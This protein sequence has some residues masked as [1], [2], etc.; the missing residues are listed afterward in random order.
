MKKAKIIQVANLVEMRHNWNRGGYKNP[1]RG[2]V[3]SPNGLAPAITTCQGGGLVPKIIRK[4]MKRNGNAYA[5]W[6]GR[7]VGEM[8]TFYYQATERFARVSEP[9]ECFCIKAS[10][11]GVTS[12]G[13]KTNRKMDKLN[14]DDFALR[15]LTPRVCLRLMDVDDKHIDTLEH[16]MT[17]TKSGKPKRVLSDSALYKLAGNSIVVNCM[18]EIFE[19]LLYPKAEAEQGDQLKLF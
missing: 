6:K 14:I 9:N 13:V 5:V 12:V 3:Y 18:T 17:T 1:N 10:G 8:Q 11:G 7:K 4:K 19:N 15:R 16:A 2:R